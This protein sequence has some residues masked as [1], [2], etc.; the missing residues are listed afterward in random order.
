MEA[1]AKSNWKDQEQL[2]QLLHTEGLI[3]LHQRMHTGD[4]K[5]IPK[6]NGKNEHTIQA[7]RPIMCLNTIRKIITKTIS[8]RMYQLIQAENYSM[9]SPN[10]FGYQKNTGVPQALYTAKLNM[11]HLL[12]QNKLPS[13]YS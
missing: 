5:G 1:L 11:Q 2:I 7:W 8:N 12:N 10:Q 3:K 13:K 9:L 6:Y 4:I